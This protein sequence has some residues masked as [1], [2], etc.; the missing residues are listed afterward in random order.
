MLDIDDIFSNLWTQY[1]TL[2]PE[3]QKIH[4]LFIAKGNEVV[5]DHIALR[6]FNHPKVSKLVLAKPFLE[7]GY[8]VCDHYHFSEKKLDA[9]HLENAQQPDYPKVFI[10]EL[11]LDRFS[12]QLNHEISLIVDQI[13]DQ[14]LSQ[15][16]FIYSGVSWNKVSKATYEKMREESEYA[17]WVAAFGYAANHF[18]VKVNSLKTLDTL[19]KVNQL[20]EEAGY[21]INTVGGKIKGSPSIYLEQS[22]T[23]ANKQAVEFSDGSMV[24][25]S[26][27]YEFARRYPDKSGREFSG[28]VADNA[29]KI[30]ESTNASV[31]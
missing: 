13:P 18:T 23:L 2:N 3:V 19:E 27:F 31:N 9:F 15:P 21:E 6:T 5:N 28:F 1:T 22:S 26:C 8:K 14:T 17:A 20:I 7:R 12:K 10:S 29:D 30:F 11:I 24:I 4:D 25:P 16:S